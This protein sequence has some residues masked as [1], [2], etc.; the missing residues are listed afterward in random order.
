MTKTAWLGWVAAGLLCLDVGLQALRY[1]MPGFAGPDFIMHNTHAH[2]WLF[3]HAGFGAVAL[4]VGVVQLLPQLRA[5]WRAGHRWLGRAYM[6]AC[7]VSG[8]AGL[9]IAMGTQAGP[10]AVA[11]FAGAAVVALICAVQ[12]W[13]RAIGRRYDEHRAWAIR[14]YSVI[15][16]AVTL[17]LWLPA[18]GLAHLDFMEAYRVISFLAWV[19][20]L[21][22]AEIYL[23]QGRRRPA[24]PVRAAVVGEA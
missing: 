4:M 3:V 12:A 19:P 5:R 23:S 6:V 22:V 16:A 2:P 18:A 9:A 10:V 8:A 14:S 15:F 24:R 1:L 21:V 13:R 20:N 7:L 17:R 11:G